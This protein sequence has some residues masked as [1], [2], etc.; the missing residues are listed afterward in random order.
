MAAQAGGSLLASFLC[1]VA[2]LRDLSLPA[3]EAVAVRSRAAGRAERSE[4]RSGVLDGAAARS[5]VVSVA[6][7]GEAYRSR[8]FV[9][10]PENGL[11]YFPRKK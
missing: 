3:S 6:R 1:E 9:A 5:Y 7:S 2:L 8:A 10:G 4:P 11:A